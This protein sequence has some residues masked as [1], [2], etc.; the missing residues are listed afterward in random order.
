MLGRAIAGG[1]LVRGTEKDPE[2][3]WEGN[4]IIFLYQIISR[5]YSI[6]WALLLYLVGDLKTPYVI[7][8][9]VGAK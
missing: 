4:R 7:L 9:G 1:S 3:V 6:D 5:P 2:G 8:V